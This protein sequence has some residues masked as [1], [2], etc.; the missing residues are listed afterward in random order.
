MIR[1]PAAPAVL[2]SLTGG[3]HDLFGP[4][5]RLRA[6]LA[7]VMFGWVLACFLSG[8]FITASPS[9]VSMRWLPQSGWGVLILLTA[10]GM[11]YSTPGRLRGIAGTLTALLMLWFALSFLMSNVINHTGVSTGLPVYLALCWA[12]LMVVRDGAR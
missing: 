3:A 1:Y 9:Y 4:R 5:E 11:V 6:L 7:L 10:L 2:R 12:S 8:P